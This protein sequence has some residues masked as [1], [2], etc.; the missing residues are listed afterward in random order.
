MKISR[1]VV[2]AHY[3]LKDKYGKISVSDKVMGLLLTS[4]EESK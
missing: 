3:I 1:S 4:D 2:C